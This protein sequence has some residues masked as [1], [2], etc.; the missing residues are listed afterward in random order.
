MEAT[1]AYRTCLSPSARSWPKADPALLTADE[2]TVAIQINGKLKATLQMPK[3]IASRKASPKQKVL[4]SLHEIRDA[5]KDKNQVDKIHLSYRT[6]SSM[7]R[8]QIRSAL[9]IAVVLVPL[10][11]TGCGFKPLYGKNT[12]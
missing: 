1:W 10:L 11:L 4:G 3:D 2:V 6:E 12:G 8:G 5:L 9:D 7:Y